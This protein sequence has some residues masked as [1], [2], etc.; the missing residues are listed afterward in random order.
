M[1][2]ALDRDGRILDE[3]YGATKRDVIDK[4]LERN[5]D[6]HEFR[7]RTL[8]EADMPTAHSPLSEKIDELFTYHAPT[9]EQ[10][11]KY[12]AIRAAAKV[13]A[14]VLVAN[15]PPS[16]DQTAAIRKLRECVHVANA[17]IALNGLS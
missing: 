6:A 2:Q 9:P 11:P 12:E 13:F 17:A 5:P 4:L 8:Q 14:H 3:V 15:T 16:A 7:I 10:I 1:G